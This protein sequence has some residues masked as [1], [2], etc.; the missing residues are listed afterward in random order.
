MHHITCLAGSWGEVGV[1]EAVQ[2]AW[3]SEPGDEAGVPAHLG[4][5]CGCWW[6]P[7]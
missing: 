6:H 3:V 7:A 2:S 5:A 1:G 4:L